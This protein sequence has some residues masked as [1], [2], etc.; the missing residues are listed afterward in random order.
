MVGHRRAEPGLLQQQL[1]SAE[2][3]FVCVL[4]VPLLLHNG[5]PLAI[6][7]KTRPGQARGGK[8]H[9]VRCTVGEECVQAVRA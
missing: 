4:L 5:Q 1:C 8:E 2:S 7:R 3:R 6:V 9:R